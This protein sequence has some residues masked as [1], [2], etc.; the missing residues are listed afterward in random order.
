VSLPVPSPSESLQGPRLPDRLFLASTHREVLAALTRGLGGPTWL[1]SVTG[2]AGTGKTTI[3]R[4]GLEANGVAAAWVSGRGLGEDVLDALRRAAF[5]GPSS[6]RAEG[7]LRVIVVDDAHEL[8]LEFLEEL[9]GTRDRGRG[10]DGGDGAPTLI[11][12]GRPELWPRLRGPNLSDQNG[13][14]ELRTVLFPMSYPEAERYVDHVLRRAGT[15]TGKI[16]SP[17]AL[18]EI[19]LRSRGNPRRIN[20]ELERLLVARLRTTHRDRDA[21][22]S[23]RQSGRAERLAW[24]PS[25]WERVRE[26]FSRAVDAAAGA[27]HARPDAEPVRDEGSRRGAKRSRWRRRLTKAKRSRLTLATGVVIAVLAALVAILPASKDPHSGETML[28]QASLRLR[29]TGAA[30]ARVAHGQR[31]GVVAGRAVNTCEGGWPCVATPRPSRAVEIEPRG[32]G[33]SW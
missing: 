11:L 27:L 2:E 17:K 8:P 20:A 32:A 12:I 6:A 31:G 23:P 24:R 25:T 4:A 15:S 16:M 10:A 21:Q 26:A 14:A 1:I 9:S 19:L 28:S 33:S 3:V 30:L 7:S 29:D 13:R 5:S 18:H 22:P